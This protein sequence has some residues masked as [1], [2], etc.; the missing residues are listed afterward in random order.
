MPGRQH[1]LNIQVVQH[2][3]F[4]IDGRDLG[5]RQPNVPPLSLTKLASTTN[6]TNPPPGRGGP[7]TIF[8]FPSPNHYARPRP[9]RC[10]PRAKRRPPP[11]AQRGGS[12]PPAPPP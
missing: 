7:V 1:E 2:P 10:P 11:P 5:G 3:H 9:P 8:L 6:C 12:P 4:E